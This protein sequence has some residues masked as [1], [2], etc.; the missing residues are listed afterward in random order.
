MGRVTNGGVFDPKGNYTPTGAWDFT[1]TSSFAIPGALVGH[2]TYN[3][4]VDGG[5]VGAITPAVNFT[6]PN[7]AILLG[8]VLDFTTAVTSGGSATVA[9]GTTAGS[10]VTSIL[11]ATAK[12]SCTGLVAMVPVFT[13]ATYVKMTAAGQIQITVAVAN[14]TAGVC[15]IFVYYVVSP[16]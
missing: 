5:V 15:E 3:F 9:I 2:A 11:A 7:K 1:Q 12:G 14:L 8:G 4:A 6:L 16:T 10:S 13:N